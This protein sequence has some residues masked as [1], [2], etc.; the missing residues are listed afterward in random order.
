MILHHG[1]QRALYGFA[2]AMA[3]VVALFQIYKMA[4]L[5]NCRQLIITR[6][7]HDALQAQRSAL[8]Q[9]AAGRGVDALPFKSQLLYCPLVPKQHLGAST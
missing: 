7:V 4:V 1:R 3:L 2:L 8:H 6:S 5:A 9:G